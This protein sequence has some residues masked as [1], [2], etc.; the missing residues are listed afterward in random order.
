MLNGRVIERQHGTRVRLVNVECVF[1][2]AHVNFPRT[3][4]VLGGQVHAQGECVPVC[5]PERVEEIVVRRR[6]G[7]G[8]G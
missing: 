4:A 5:C 3:H 8:G 7:G 2:A 6:F 1:D